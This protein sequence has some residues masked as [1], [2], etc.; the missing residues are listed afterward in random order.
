M[1]ESWGNE[2]DVVKEHRESLSGAGK[3]REL[4]RHSF[5]LGRIGMVRTIDFIVLGFFLSVF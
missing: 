5:S 1:L 4:G 3:L 2:L